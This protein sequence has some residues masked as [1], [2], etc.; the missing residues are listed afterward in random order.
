MKKTIRQ[1][2][3]ALLSLLM[4]AV[5]FAGC[6]KTDDKIT[7][8]SR[9]DGSGTRGAFIELFG[10]EEKDADGNKIDRTIAT[11]ETTNSTSVMMTSISGNASG[12]GYV[13]L[14][15]LNNTVKALT[16]DGAAASVDNIKNGTYKI[17]RPFLIATR[18]DVNELTEDF[19]R[20]IM[21]ESGQAVVAEKGYIPQ[22]SATAYTTD[23]TRSGKITIE[24][25]SS[26]TPVTVPL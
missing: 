7:V 14:G 5:L 6:G 24:G 9:E 20:F 15:S 21:S 26:V 18:A 10:I 19:I 3:G 16:I 13:S 22:D 2:L 25:S 11:A 1:T 23:G 12:I 17:S 8:V 4:V